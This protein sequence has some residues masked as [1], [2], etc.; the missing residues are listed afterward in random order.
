MWILKIYY[1]TEPNHVPERKTHMVT[2]NYQKSLNAFWS[3]PFVPHHAPV[4]FRHCF[5]SAIICSYLPSPCWECQEAIPG[6]PSCPEWRPIFQCVWGEDPP[7]PTSFRSPDLGLALASPVNIAML[8]GIFIGSGS[9]SR[10]LFLTIKL[11]GESAKFWRLDYLFYYFL[12]FCVPSCVWASCQFF[13]NPRSCPAIALHILC[14]HYLG[15]Y[16]CICSGSSF[17]STTDTWGRLLLLDQS[18][19]VPP[20]PG[21]SW[22]C[23]SVHTMQIWSLSGR[24]GIVLC[25]CH[26]DD[27]TASLAF[28]AQSLPAPCLLSTAC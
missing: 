1:Q 4:G 5:G 21:G 20:V 9:L 27:G 3:G 11:S 12:Q 2:K 26:V 16:H 17:S 15:Q 10:A 24:P 13:L 28:V 8:C 18:A 6:G 14:L 7:A 25:D 22:N 23:R 19:C